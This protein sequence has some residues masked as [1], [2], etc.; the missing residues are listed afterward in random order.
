[1]Q[2]GQM[3]FGFTIRTTD[4]GI[5]FEGLTLL[6]RRYSQIDR[7]RVRRFGGIGLG[8]VICR[9]QV[10]AMAAQIGVTSQPI[11]GS[12]FNF[13]VTLAIEQRARPPTDELDGYQIVVQFADHAKS[14]RLR[15]LVAEDNATNRLVATARLERLGHDVT[16]ASNGSQAVAAMKPA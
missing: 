14:R 13:D 4:I 11:V 15:I 7:T 5:S 12:D 8:L 2:C 16:T 9:K 6:F 3:R 10:E 1:M